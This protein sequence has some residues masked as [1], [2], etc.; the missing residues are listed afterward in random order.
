MSSI[1]EKRYVIIKKRPMAAAP[2]SAKS[3]RRGVRMA[4]I[5]RNDEARMR[6]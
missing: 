5:L 3:K 4:K 1:E 2:V 6:Q